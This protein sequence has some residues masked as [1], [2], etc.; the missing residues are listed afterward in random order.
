MRKFDKTYE[1]LLEQYR[2]D[3]SLLG[4]LGKAV[5]FPLKA[6]GA[7]GKA[8]GNAIANVVK[9]TKIGQAFGSGEGKPSEKLKVV[10]ELVSEIIPILDKTEKH[11]TKKF[12][13]KRLSD[14][15]QEMFSINDFY[16]SETRLGRTKLDMMNFAKETI[17]N[18]D[19]S[20]LVDSKQNLIKS[21]IKEVISSKEWKQENQ[22]VKIDENETIKQIKNILKSQTSRAN[23][24]VKFEDKL[25]WLYLL[26]PSTH[27]I[28]V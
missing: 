1:R 6:V 10:M 20:S 19:F 2:L 5:M 26:A 22:N 7:I 11:S 16:L 9:G 13:F 8:Y 14:G 21:S 28:E 25:N 24:K 27:I 23:T 17:S 3:E 18:M 15:K 4:N 12:K